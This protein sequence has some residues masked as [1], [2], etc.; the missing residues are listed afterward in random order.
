MVICDIAHNYT[1]LDFVLKQLNSLQGNKKH[2]IMGLSKDKEILKILSCLPNNY[3]YYFCGSSNSRI[4][5]PNLLKEHFNK[6]NLKYNI[7]DSSIDAYQLIMSKSNQND[8]MMVTGS[9][10]IISDILKYLYKI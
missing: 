3:H 9:T 5:N 4:I 6:Y 10:F 7:F 2:I 1:A 8:V